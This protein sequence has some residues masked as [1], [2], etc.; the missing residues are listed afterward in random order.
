MSSAGNKDDVAVRYEGVSTD[1]TETPKTKGGGGGG[2][3]RGAR[4]RINNYSILL[5]TTALINSLLTFGNNSYSGY[6]EFWK[7]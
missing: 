5:F 3:I 6:T 1:Q 7:R 2:G 4:G